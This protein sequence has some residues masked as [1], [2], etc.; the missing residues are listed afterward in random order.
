MSQTSIVDPTQLKSSLESLGYN[1]RDF[2]SYWRAAAIYRGGDN[3]TALKIYK[4]SGVWTDFAD[5]DKSY[6][7]K[8]LISLTLNTKDDSVIDKYV[9][10]DLQNIISNEVKEKIEMEKI[11][12]ESML[13]NLLPHL[14]FYSKKMI[15]PDTLNFYKCGYAT[16]GQLFRRIVFPIYNSQ[17]EIHGFSARATIWNKDS[18]FPKWKHLGKK[19]N[20]V[21]P[22]HVK[23]GGIEIVRE[24]I[25]ETGTVIIVESIGDS[26]ALFENGYANNLVTFGLGISSKLC[27]TL[28]ELNPDKIIIAY[29]NDATS[30]LNHGLV[31]SCKSYLQLCSVF[32][33]T[34]L[35]IKLPLA[36]DF[37]D[38]NLL[39]LEG[40]D[41]LFTLWENKTVK[42]E[43]QIK[44]IY[45]IAVQNNF[46]QNLIKKAEELN[47]SIS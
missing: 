5:G 34:K 4:N 37:S 32:D 44:K 24:K 3:S 15:S 8:R 11:Y 47:E 17:G 29:N 2:G 40:Q 20:W 27:S 14:D 38:M 26:M 9:K 35:Q 39:T 23:R 12:P 33:H 28:V 18:T 13:E 45:E 21:Y 7:I 41:N 46:P 25:A 22:L 43:A 19:T 6:P 42:R 1:L 36:N 30:K 10:F 31:S 16:A